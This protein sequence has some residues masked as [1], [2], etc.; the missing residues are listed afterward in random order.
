MRSLRRKGQRLLVDAPQADR[1]TLGG[2]YATNASGPRRFGAGR[3]RDQIIGV[4][5]VNAE[6]AVV[7]GGGRVVKNVAGYDFPKLLTGSLGTLGIITQLTL[8]V[9]PSPKP[10][11]WSGP[12]FGPGADL[13]GILD[14][15][16]TSATRPMAVELLNPSGGRKAGEGA[17]AARRGLGAGGRVRGQRGVGCVAGR[18]VP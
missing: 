5:F 10:R 1:A 2:V 15:L 3:P 13:A 4:S 14:R 9:R 8:K 11:R 17:R 6:G 7:K 18:S 12:E 16:N